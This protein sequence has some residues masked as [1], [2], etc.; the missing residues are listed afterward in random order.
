MLSS[1]DPGT[2]VPPTRLAEA[3]VLRPEVIRMVDVCKSYYMGD[4]ELEVLHRVNL[5]VRQGEF[6]SILGPSGSGKS[7]LMNIL[8]C[9]DVPT[10]GTYELAGSRVADLN[11]TQ[12][13]RIRNSEVGF[14]FQSFQLLPRLTA[15]ENVEL[16]LIYTSAGGAER[17][18]R[19]LGL[20]ERVGLANKTRNLPNQLSGGQQQ[21]VAIA[22]ALVT[23][24]SVLLADEPTG[25]LDQQT[26]AQVMALFEEIN[27]DG[28]T[29]IMITHEPDI[30]AHASRIVS[31]L[32]GNLTEHDA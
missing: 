2:V 15:L 1:A 16:P 7:T 8:G 19:A 12:L 26:G 27:R 24:P 3:A 11:E 6:V 30:A 32:D 28:R 5:T 18:R 4:E 13:A 21:R 20:L 22:R 10:S 25:A 14:V 29:V 31:I 17:R 9:L 23:D